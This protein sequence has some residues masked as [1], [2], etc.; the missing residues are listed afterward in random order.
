MDRGGLRDP[1]EADLKASRRRAA[2]VGEDRGGVQGAAQGGER[3]QDG[4]VDGG[5]E[6]RR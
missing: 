2:A 4:E 6:T 5:A 1:K 3:D